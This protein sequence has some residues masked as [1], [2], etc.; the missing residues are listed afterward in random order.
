MSIKFTI[1][2]RT[3]GTKQPFFFHTALGNNRVVQPSETYRELA[4]VVETIE[5]IWYETAK[6]QL[7]PLTSPSAMA[8]PGSPLNRKQR[9]RVFCDLHP[10]PYTKDSIRP[11][12]FDEPRRA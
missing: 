4:E 11:I 8:R 2:K 1:E 12:N 6:A 9:I 10:V 5:A 7:H 3:R